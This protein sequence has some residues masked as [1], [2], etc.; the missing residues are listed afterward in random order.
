MIPETPQ[1]PQEQQNP[2]GIKVSLD[3]DDMIQQKLAPEYQKFITDPEPM[4]KVFLFNL[5][6]YRVKY[7]TRLENVGMNQMRPKQTKTYYIDKNARLMNET[8]A[9]YLYN[10]FTP[11]LNQL[12]S[13]S[14]ITNRELF[15]MWNGKIDSTNEALLD[16]VIDDNI[17]N[18]RL[19]RHSDVIGFLCSLYQIGMKSRNGFTLTKLAESFMTIIRGTQEQN[20]QKKEGFI[21]KMGGAF[22]N[23]I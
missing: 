19:A 10:G 6:G 21:D 3:R 2:D 9:L 16:A 8:G 14:N 1:N 5:C 13:T 11:L 7:E 20:P 17:Y 15:D 22:K 4:E 23:L 12:S 18:Y